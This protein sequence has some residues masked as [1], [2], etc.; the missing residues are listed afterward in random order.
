MV[1]AGMPYKAI[2]PSDRASSE[3]QP[4]SHRL[5]VT[6]S[7]QGVDTHAGRSVGRSGTGDAVLIYKGAGGV[8]TF[9]G[10][11]Q[12]N[13]VVHVYSDAGEDLLVNEIGTYQGEEVVPAGPAVLQINADGPWTVSIKAQ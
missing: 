6:P 3:R 11:G 4:S 12:D 1:R 8:A 10:K 5:I 9:I 13:F 7:I 2:V